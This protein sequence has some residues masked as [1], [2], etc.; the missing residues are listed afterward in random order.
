VL[1]DGVGHLR[2]LLGGDLDHHAHHV[3]GRGVA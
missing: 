3:A 1:V 2:R